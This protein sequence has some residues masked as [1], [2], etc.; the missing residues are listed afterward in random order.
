[1]VITYE[2]ST[3]SL[4]SKTGFLLTSV[5]VINQSTINEIINNNRIVHTL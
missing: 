1:M 2:K 5:I 4:A 3:C